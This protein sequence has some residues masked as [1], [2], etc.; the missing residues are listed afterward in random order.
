MHPQFGPP[1]SKCVRDCK[2]IRSDLE[3]PVMRKTR[4]REAILAVLSGE[5][6]PLTPTEIV[7]LADQAVPGINLATVYRNLKLLAE[8]GQVISVECFG[9]TARYEVAGLDHHHHFLC[10]D[11]DRLFD[12]PGCV[13]DFE[14]IAPR[15]FE[16][17]RHHVQLAGRCDECAAG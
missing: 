1:S 4:Q 15:G 14:S 5:R 17:R 9:Q 3:S 10:E 2:R 11:C 7:G 6:R 16:V 8:T 13:E 12:L